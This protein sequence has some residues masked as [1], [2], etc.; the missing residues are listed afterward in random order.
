[1]SLVRVQLGEPVSKK[2]VLQRTGFF[3]NL[4]LAKFFIM[5]I[6]TH[7]T[8]KTTPEILFEA[9]A[10]PAHLVN[11]WG[12]KGLAN[13][14]EIFEFKPGGA[15]TM[16]SLAPGNKIFANINQF[17]DIAKPER[18]AFLHADPSPRFHMT[19]TFVA[20]S[21]TTTTISW[22]MQFEPNADNEKFRPMVELAS[23]QN[24]N[25]LEIYL[26]NVKL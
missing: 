8:I 16:T 7:R 24:L 21:A 19:M 15:W 14:I 3:V 11:W 5:E 9:F 17:V 1:L 26:P 6:S 22:H 13:K 10:N 4:F 12:P 25:R 20:E 23:A 2:P 18:I